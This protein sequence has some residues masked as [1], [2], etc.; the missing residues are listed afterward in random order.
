M[1]KRNLNL[2]TDYIIDSDEPVQFEFDSMT[3]D[4][5]NDMFDNYMK[6][7]YRCFKK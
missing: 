2:E 4:E 3:D 6:E 1:K 5:I 7:F